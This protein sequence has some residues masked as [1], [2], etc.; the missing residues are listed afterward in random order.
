MLT[1]TCDLTVSGEL[2]GPGS[3][4]RTKA[5]RIINV[6]TSLPIALVGVHTIRYT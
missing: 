6:L 1:W 5:E 2:Q 4:D 3:N